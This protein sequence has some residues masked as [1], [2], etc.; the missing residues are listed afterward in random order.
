MLNYHHGVS[1][2][3]SG[4]K[5]ISLPTNVTSMYQPMDQGIIRAWKANARA[6]LLSQ[7]VGPVDHRDELRVLGYKQKLGMQGLQYAHDAHVLDGIQILNRSIRNITANTVVNCWIHSKSG[8]MEQ[9]KKCCNSTGKPHPS[10]STLEHSPGLE[11]ESMA[12]VGP[13]RSTV[14]IEMQ[15]ESDEEDDDLYNLRCFDGTSCIDEELMSEAERITGLL[16]SLN[17]DD[18]QNAAS[19]VTRKNDIVKWLQD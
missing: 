14:M 10:F 18:D 11:V 5:S 3:I 15:G 1:L 19:Y 17:M 7:I 12:L 16:G 8:T 9:I 4:V 6:D 13:Y 2:C